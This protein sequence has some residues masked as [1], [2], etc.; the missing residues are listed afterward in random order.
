MAL[1]IG[2]LQLAV[3]VTK[4]LPH[5]HQASHSAMAWW[6]PALVV[7]MILRPPAWRTS[8]QCQSWAMPSSHLPVCLTSAGL[9]RAV[10]PE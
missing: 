1:V 10:Q 9:G 3:A 2:G 6:V 4:V 8:S 7:S 5:S